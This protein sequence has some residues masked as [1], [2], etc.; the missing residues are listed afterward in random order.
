MHKSRV[1]NISYSLGGSKAIYLGQLII[2]WFP[3]Q[4]GHWE[5]LSNERGMWSREFCLFEEGCDGCLAESGDVVV[6][7]DRW[8]P[9]FTGCKF[10]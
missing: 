7:G 1:F 9:E 10:S 3:E 5:V 2:L 6:T 8:A 4:A